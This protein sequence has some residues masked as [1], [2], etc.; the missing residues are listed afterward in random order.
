MPEFTGLGFGQCPRHVFYL[1]NTACFLR[2]VSMLPAMSLK[3][4]RL[5]FSHTPASFS[6]VSACRLTFVRLPFAKNASAVLCPAASHYSSWGSA[7]PLPQ[8]RPPFLG[9][10]IAANITLRHGLQSPK[11]SVS[12]W[13]CWTAGKPSGRSTICQSPR[14][15][16]E[17]WRLI[18]DDS[19]NL[20]QS[21]AQGSHGQAS[22]A[23]YSQ[24]VSYCFVLLTIAFQLPFGC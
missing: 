7:L 1:L 10:P 12:L 3:S 15:S 23:A 16:C 17:W 24:S 13:T 11:Q 18:A 9:L 20:M 14:R 6:Y 5:L 21:T 8:L 22:P 4:S 2:F 19:L